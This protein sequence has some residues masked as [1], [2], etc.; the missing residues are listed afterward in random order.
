MSRSSK[1][2]GRLTGDKCCEDSGEPP[3]GGR[4]LS[5]RR[6]VRASLTAGRWL[7]EG[8]KSCRNAL[9]G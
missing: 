6:A 1:L 5:L 7:G 2:C 3:R 9:S 4:H 8:L